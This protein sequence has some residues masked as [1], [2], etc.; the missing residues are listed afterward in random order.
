MVHLVVILLLPL[1]VIGFL[2]WRLRLLNMECNQA[3]D[4]QE[5]E[6]IGGFHGRHRE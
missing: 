6:E 5:S 1:C 2:V 4:D 3:A